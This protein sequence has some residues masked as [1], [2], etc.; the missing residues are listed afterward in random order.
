MLLPMYLICLLPEFDR[1][2]NVPMYRYECG[3]KKTTPQTKTL[4]DI[5]G[6][7]ERY[8]AFKRRPARASYAFANNAGTNN[9]APY[10]LSSAPLLSQFR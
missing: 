2:G 10:V 3:L 8:Y 5:I 6:W 1:L 7:K 9:F 4:S